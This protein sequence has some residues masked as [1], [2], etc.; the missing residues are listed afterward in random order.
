MGL[1]LDHRFS[2]T[3]A[4]ATVFA[5]ALV[6]SG[7]AWR[8]LAAQDA[9]AALRDLNRA[10]EEADTG[11]FLAALEQVLMKND[12]RSVGSA[13]T[14][15]STLAEKAMARL[16]PAEVMA[17]HGR[18]ASAFAVVSRKE[19]VA[20]MQ[21]LLQ[22]GKDWSGR[23][24]LLDAA[25]FTK[26]LNLRECA[27]TALGDQH[28]VVIR[29]AL[30][31][32]T[33]AREVPV[34]EAIIKRYVDLEAKKA[35]D[36][37]PQWSRTLLACHSALKTLFKVDL[38]AAV[39]YKNWFQARKDSPDLFNPKQYGEGKGLTGPT[40]FGAPI[41]GKNLVFILDVSGSMTTT[42]L[43]PGQRDPEVGATSVASA[44]AAVR[45]RPPSPRQRMFRAKNEF[46]RMIGA[47]PSDVR[48][49]LITYSSEVNTWK[50]TMV[51]AGDE[52]K[53]SAVEY[54]QGLKPDGVT[55]TDLALEAAFADLAVD[56]IYL[57][58]DGV[59]T[60]IGNTGPALP[61]DSPALIQAILGRAREL[62]F[63]RGVRVFTLGFAEAE[64]EFLKKLAAE[65][66]GSY[67]RIK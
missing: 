29:R 19:A 67:V 43:L 41:T 39:D 40:L 65:N 42:D 21:R 44:K 7:A 34:A 24:L 27:L 6:L 64:E 47:L 20:E 61:E 28:P 23:L 46:T 66:A 9:R 35:K 8:P 57:V 32:L 10:A 49:N 15:Y 5:A 48:F 1:M 45:E 37:D 54:I 18:A 16:R 3:G 31:Y 59:P 53:K 4:A 36:P 13:V 63:L 11:A 62:N 25:A 12:A 56:T 58:T 50:G 14:A 17:L 38:P 60:H 2:W 55:V 22:R 30:T 26:A 33:R 52:M 51:P